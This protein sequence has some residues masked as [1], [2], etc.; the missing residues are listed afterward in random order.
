[1]KRLL[2]IHLEDPAR[3]AASRFKSIIKDALRKLMDKRSGLR[4]LLGC[5]SRINQT[6]AARMHAYDA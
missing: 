6:N 2:K 1:M 3:T 4:M 5:S